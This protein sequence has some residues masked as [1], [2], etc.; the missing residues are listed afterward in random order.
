MASKYEQEAE[1]L[2][3]A[4]D[5]AIEAIE[6]YPPKGFMPQHTEHFIQS[7]KE[8]KEEALNPEPKYKKLASLKYVQQDVFIFFQ[9]ASG[10]TVEY[11]WKKIKQQDLPFVRDNQL[12]K[13]LL[14][15]KI[16]NSIEYDYVKDTAPIFEQEGVIN[17]E[18]ASIL[19]QLL[20][21]FEIKKGKK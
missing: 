8:F 11:F 1:K 7:Y 10:N 5:I 12:L 9:E 3:K 15:K 17:K 2:A 21:D 4:I 19:N 20:L 18:E 14:K 16:K 13:I 6:L